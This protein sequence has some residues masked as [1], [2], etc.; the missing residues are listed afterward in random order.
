MPLSGRSLSPDHEMSSTSPS[1]LSL[2]IDHHHK[3][4]HHNDYHHNDQNHNHR[5]HYH[6]GNHHTAPTTEPPVADIGCGQRLRC[7]TTK[8]Y[9]STT[10]TVREAVKKT[11]F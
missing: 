11:V 10:T 2:L 3:D 1:S 4:H 7:C 5:N 6:Y 9:Y 8:I